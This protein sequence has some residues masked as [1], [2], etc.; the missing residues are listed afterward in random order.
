MSERNPH[1]RTRPCDARAARRSRASWPSWRCSARSSARP[2]PAGRRERR[3]FAGS[4]GRR[5]T[6]R[7]S[8]AASPRPVEQHI[9]KPD[10]RA[11]ECGTSRGRDA[12]IM[13]SRAQPHVP[14]DGQRR[15][16]G[17]R[18]AAGP[19]PSPRRQPPPSA[20]A[21]TSRTLR[22][23][24]HGSGRTASCARST[25]IRASGCPARRCCWR[26]CAP[27]LW[28]AWRSGG[29]VDPTL[30]GALERAG[31]AS[32]LDRARPASL[33]DALLHAPARRAGP[34]QPA[35]AMAPDRR[36]RAGG[37]GHA[38]ARACGS[39]PAARARVCAR[40]PSRTASPVTP[41]SSST[42]AGTSRSAASVRSWSPTTWRS[43][44]R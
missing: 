17:D 42:A 31:Y 8:A 40:M 19:R 5:S 9:G 4:T 11:L 28:A 18:R 37:D 44:I 36:R 34:L 23:G 3:W 21:R 16:A 20:S 7:S 14:F 27:P 30:V 10:A 13:S 41:A 2:R 6:K 33:H 12:H 22:L 24:F 38:P 43:S 1:P 39:T 15:A 29:L 32:S 35:E 26:P 25:P